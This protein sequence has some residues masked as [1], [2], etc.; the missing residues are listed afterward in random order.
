M[1]NKYMTNFFVEASKIKKIVLIAVML[2]LIG[3]CLALMLISKKGIS[4]TEASQQSASVPKVIS[5][6]QGV[7]IV[8]NGLQGSIL[9]LK[10]KNN[11]AEGVSAFVISQDEMDA[12]H[13]LLH[14]NKTIASGV[15]YDCAFPISTGKVTPIILNAVVLEDGTGIGDDYFVGKINKIR[16]GKTVASKKILDLMVKNKADKELDEKA[17]R[18]LRDDIMQYK[19]SIDNSSDKATA[20]IMGEQLVADDILNRLEKIEEIKSRGGQATGEIINNQTK[21]LKGVLSRY[22]AL[23]PK[24]NSVNKKEGGQ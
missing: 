7:E 17:I 18:G 15:S 20:I 9:S 24:A 11:R 12:T 23:K 3:T 21:E 10:L 8:E 2:S 6:V 13:D 4:S 1:G 16:Q 5:K 14:T 22:E 19:P